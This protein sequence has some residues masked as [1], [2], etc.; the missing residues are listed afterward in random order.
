M[1][2]TAGM[3]VCAGALLLS[4]AVIPPAGAMT[5]ELTIPVYTPGWPETGRNVIVDS[6][7][8]FVDAFATAFRMNPNLQAT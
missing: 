6:S 4:R 7:S 8:D 2:T 1:V 3:V 5:Y